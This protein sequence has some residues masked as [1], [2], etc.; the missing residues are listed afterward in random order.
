MRR[1]PN[2]STV[3]GEGA[4]GKP[5]SVAVNLTTIVFLFKFTSCRI[6]QG[7]HSLG[8]LI[9]WKPGLAGTRLTSLRSIEPRKRVSPHPG[10]SQG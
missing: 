4:G 3:P 9:L 6:Q 10:N 1:S 7:N 2:C 5:Q 8:K